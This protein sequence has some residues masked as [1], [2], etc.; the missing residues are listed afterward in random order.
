MKREYLQID[1]P[2]VRND[3]VSGSIN[4]LALFFRNRRFRNVIVWYENWIVQ[5]VVDSTFAYNVGLVWHFLFN[6]LSIQMSTAN[7]ENVKEKVQYTD[8]ESSHAQNAKR[9]SSAVIFHEKSAH[10]T[11]KSST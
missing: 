3:V 1:I 5:S 2:H 10:K 4:G 7:V 11:A 6:F 9:C 8:K